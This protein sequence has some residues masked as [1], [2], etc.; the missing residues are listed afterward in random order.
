MITMAWPCNNNGK[1]KVTQKG[2]AI[3][4]MTLSKKVQ[5]GSNRHHEEKTNKLCGP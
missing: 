4:M 5:S 2:I 1:N 3:K